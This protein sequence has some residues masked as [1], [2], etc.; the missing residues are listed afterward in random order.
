MLASA[1]V[2]ATF[3]ALLPDAPAFRSVSAMPV[4]LAQDA[5]KSATDTAREASEAARQT[6]K[7]AAEAARDAA[8]D[9]REAAEDPGATAAASR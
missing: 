4:A 7:E 2:A 5:A 9:A 3:V 6:A 8:D 1:L